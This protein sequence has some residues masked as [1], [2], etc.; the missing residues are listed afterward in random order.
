MKCACIA[1]D[2]YTFDFYFWNEPVSHKW[3]DRGFCTMHSQLLHMVA[4]FEDVGHILNMDNLF[5]SVKLALESYS[6]PIK[7]GIPGVIHKNNR[8]VHPCVLQ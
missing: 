4:K 5:I 7:V 6:L 3:I 8:A 1:D 2:G